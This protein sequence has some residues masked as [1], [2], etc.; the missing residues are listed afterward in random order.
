MLDIKQI[1]TNTDFVKER[2]EKRGMDPVVIDEILELDEARRTLIQKTEELKANRNKVSERI[3]L[4]KRNKE[5]ADTEIKEMQEVGK[6][7]A[8]IDAKL[9]EL[10]ADF[11][12]KMAR[13][14]NLIHEEV[15]VGADDSENVEIR[16]S[17]IHI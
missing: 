2:T 10:S 9:K 5:D 13:I 3:A 16:L 7:I 11:N 1:R 12:D 6:E 14:P 4:K 8:D 17:L 15:P